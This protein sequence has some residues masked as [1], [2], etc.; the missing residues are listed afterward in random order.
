MCGRRWNFLTAL[1]LLCFRSVPTGIRGLPGRFAVG[2]RIAVLIVAVAVIS[3][4]VSTVMIAMMVSAVMM[5]MMMSAVVVLPVMI[6]R[7]VAIRPHVRV[8]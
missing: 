6:V 1:V 5:A 3:V 7:I 2:V 4:M 8:S